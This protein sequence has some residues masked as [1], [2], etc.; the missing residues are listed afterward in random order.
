MGVPVLTVPGRSFA[1]RVCASLVSAAGLADF[2]CDTPEDYVA[3][4]IALGRDRAALA[5]ARAR[6]LAAR[7]TAPLFDTPRLVR[8][9]ERLF[10]GMWEE[11]RA[12]RLPQPDLTN[13]DNY[14]RIGAA[15]AHD[16]ELGFDPTL[17]DRWRTAVA[18]RHAYS[19]LPADARYHPAAG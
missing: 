11:F 12:G 13:L 6:L 9:L 5:K 19:P 15:M 1:A 18:R 10:R 7:D 16:G 14:L 17:D 4:A 8:E 3:R 2:V